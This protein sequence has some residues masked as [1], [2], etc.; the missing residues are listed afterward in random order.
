MP[1]GEIIN[2]QQLREAL[3]DL[4]LEN[5][6]ELGARFVSSVGHLSVNSIITQ[7]LKTA[8]DPNRTPTELATAYKNAKAFGIEKYTS[9]GRDANWSAQ[10]EHFVATAL[11]ACLLPEEQV[12]QQENLAW[13][14]AMQARMA[15]NCEMIL[16]DRGEVDNE[17]IRQYVI[18]GEFLAQP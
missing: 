5:Q 10:A 16:N 14:A 13:K 4:S 15:R 2:D 18:A 11:T 1:P 7:G 17:A 3:N 6:R 12:T 9:C 8:G